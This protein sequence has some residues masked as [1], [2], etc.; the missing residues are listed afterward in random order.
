LLGVKFFVRFF[1]AYLVEDCLNA[2]LALIRGRWSVLQAYWQGW[3]DYLEGLSALRKERQVIQR[4]RVRFDKD[5]FAPQKMVPDPLMQRG[6]PLL[7]RDIIQSCYLPLILAAKTRALPEFVT[8]SGEPLFSGLFPKRRSLVSRLLG[9][10]RAEGLR[11]LG[12]RIGKSVQ[13]RLGRV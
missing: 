2:V 4:K 13:W 9:I 7:T 1:L 11:G 3:S 10:W 12:Y 8:E 6:L 5:M